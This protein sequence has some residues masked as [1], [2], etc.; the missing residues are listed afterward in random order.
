VVGEKNDGTNELDKNLDAY[1]E[2]T[3]SVARDMNLKL[4]DLRK[5]FQQ[6]LKAN[7]P[8]N[9]DQGILTYDRVHLNDDGNK[10]VAGEL[11]KTMVQN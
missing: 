2:V 1:S 7:N 11:I 9:L 5:A 4:C 6:Y 8:D 10:F 3:R